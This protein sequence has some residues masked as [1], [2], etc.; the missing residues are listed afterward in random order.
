MDASPMKI[1]V[2]GHPVATKYFMEKNSFMV[3][4]LFFKYAG[5][6]VD[7]SNENK[8]L[9]LRR[10]PITLVFQLG[11]NYAECYVQGIDQP[12]CDELDFIPEASSD[13]VFIPLNYVAEQFGMNIWKSAHSSR[14]YLVTHLSLFSRPGIIYRGN[15]RNKKVALTFDDGPDGFYTPKILDILREEGVPA[16]FFVVG[17]QVRN[18]P[19]MLKRIVREGHALGNHSWN[20]PSFPQLETAKVVQEVNSTEEEI[21]S[22]TGHLTG[23][24]RPPYGSYT[25]A[26]R[27]HL[28]SLGFH[29][30]MWSIDT[31]DWKGIEAE[32][33]LS[34]VDREISPGAIILMHCVNE[35]PK[36]LNGTVKALPTMIRQLRLQGYQFVTVPKMIIERGG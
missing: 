24:V 13:G 20:H 7:F 15:T 18:F 31:V 5:I 34:I 32:E 8:F 26:D 29:V 28:A 30:I 2:D 3:P 1:Y 27:Y 12:K 23:I 4:A 33:I 21:F 16:T 17:E 6:A 10:N 36:F 35:K 11:R 9:T 22:L 25:L 19:D 14:T